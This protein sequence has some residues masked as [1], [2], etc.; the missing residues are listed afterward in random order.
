MRSQVYLF[1]NSLDL[2]MHYLASQWVKGIGKLNEGSLVPA[3]LR[4]WQFWP[5]ICHFFPPLQSHIPVPGTANRQ[6]WVQILCSDF[7]RPPWL[8]CSFSN[9][10]DGKRFYKPPHYSVSNFKFQ[11]CCI[12]NKLAQPNHGCNWAVSE[13]QSF[14]NMPC[15]QQLVEVKC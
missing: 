11:W 10:S 13:S 12:L 15:L 5:W 4:P 7:P 2:L 9:L 1:F 8:N 6:S 14:R 3:R